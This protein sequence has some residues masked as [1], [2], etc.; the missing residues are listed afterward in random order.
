MWARIMKERFGA[1]K[2]E[3]MRLRFHTQTAGCTLTAQQPENNIVRVAMQAL[4]AVLGGTQSLHTNSLD[5][6]L[7]LP[8][9]NAVRIALRTQQVILEETGVPDSADPMGG[10]YFV[11]ALTNEIEERATALLERIDAM[12]GMV[13][14]IEQGFPQREIEKA[15]Y[16]Y[17]KAIERGDRKV[18]GLNAHTDETPAKIDVFLVDPRIEADQTAELKKRKASRDSAALNKAL[19][20]LDRA[21]AADANLFPPILD[22]AKRGATVGEICATLTEHFGR[23]RERTTVR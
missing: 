13:K 18:V 6:A 19:L 20:E 17:Q 10:S 1:K 9:D 3:S 11:E 12:G 5:E 23:Y 15:S 22:A 8:S 16:D 2:A 21:A 14:A 7:G 4:S